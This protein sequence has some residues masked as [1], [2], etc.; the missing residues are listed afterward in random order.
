MS[1]TTEELRNRRAWN[2]YTAERFRPVLSDPCRRLRPA[3][4]WLDRLT[5][6]SQKEATTAPDTYSYYS[7][8]LDW[9][10]EWLP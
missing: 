1:N 8:A 10:N 2:F 3:Y 4:D 5:H 9:A 7:E 6:Y